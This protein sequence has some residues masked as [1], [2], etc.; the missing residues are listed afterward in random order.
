MVITAPSSK[1]Q[2]DKNVEKYSNL[3]RNWATKYNRHCEVS[4][5]IIPS[6]SLIPKHSE[7]LLRKLG[8]KNPA[9]VLSEMSTASIKVN[10]KFAVS[11]SHRAPSPSSSVPSDE[12][13]FD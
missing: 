5:L 7:S 9:K 12:E 13:D 2:N 6:V 4:T 10:V 11:S 1:S 3:A 8:I